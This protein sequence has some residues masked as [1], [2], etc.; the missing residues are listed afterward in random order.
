MPLSEVVIE[1]KVKKEKPNGH[2]I[3]VTPEELDEFIK[4]KASKMDV[5]WKPQK[6]SDKPFTEVKSSFTPRYVTTPVEAKSEPLEE[7]V[8]VKE[9]VTNDIFPTTT[10]LESFR[11][12]IRQWRPFKQFRQNRMMRVNRRKRLFSFLFC[13]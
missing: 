8:E 3:F 10:R 6:V 11:A 9:V 4:Y 13:R 12:R 7:V 5:T 1:T 2:W